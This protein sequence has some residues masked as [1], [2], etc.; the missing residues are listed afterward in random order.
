[1]LDLRFIQENLEAV[2]ENCRNRNLDVDLDRL[3]ELVE[4]RRSLIAEQQ[5][6]RGNL[7]ESQVGDNSVYYPSAGQRI[8]AF[9][10]YA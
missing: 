4:K 3:S 1:M 5:S 10:H 7:D 2:R 9:L 6:L 8:G